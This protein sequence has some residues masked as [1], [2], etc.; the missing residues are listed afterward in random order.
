MSGTKHPRVFVSYSHKDLHLVRKIKKGLK[1]RQPELDVFVATD[2]IH[3]GQPTIDRIVEGIHR[4]SKCLLLVTENSLKSSWFAFETTLSLEWSEQLGRFCCV[5]ILHGISADKLPKFALFDIMPKTQLRLDSN[6]DWEEDHI[7]HVIKLIQKDIPTERQLPVG[8]VA[9]AQAWSHFFGY[10]NVVHGLLEQRIRESK[11]FQKRPGNFPI[12][13]YELISKCCDCSKFTNDKRIKKKGCLKP[14]VINRAGNKT[15]PYSLNVYR[16]EDK[17]QKYYCVAQYPNVLSAILKMEKSE[18]IQME[19]YEKE[20]QLARFN[21]TL[22]A[23]LHHDS[24]KTCHRQSRLVEFDDEHEPHAVLLDAIKTDIREDARIMESWRGK[25]GR[26]QLEDYDIETDS[27]GQSFDAVIVCGEDDE[28]KAYEIKRFLT[29]NHLKV[30][31]LL[32]GSRVLNDLDEATEQCRW[33]VLILTK[34]SLDDS[35]FNLHTINLLTKSISEK[36]VSIIPIVDG[37]TAGRIPTALKWI[38]YIDMRTEGYKERI[39]KAVKGEDIPMA[40]ENALI[41]AGNLG[42]GLAWGYIVNYMKTVLKEFGFYLQKLL[43]QENQSSIL[44]YC[45]EKLY[46]LMPSSCKCTGLVS[47]TSQHVSHFTSFTRIQDDLGGA[48]IVKSLDIY[49]I[50][51]DDNIRQQE[52]YFIGQFPAPV[53][54]LWEM[55]ESRIASIN[56]HTMEREAE[57]FRHTFECLMKGPVGKGLHTKCEIVQFDDTIPNDLQRKLVPILR[58]DT[59]RR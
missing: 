44:R 10:H 7:S 38:T 53:L 3:G 15:R 33:I 31:P 37:L 28:D 50:T 45:P 8:N 11:W 4:S 22:S 55:N 58:R 49:S 32:G 2:D 26:S 30:K 54:C 24:N 21:F 47:D 52:H 13:I 42:Y 18:H 39:C 59:R 9:H 20:M 34:K 17:G 16:I 1:K 19:T 48:N 29:K 36:N 46:V 14:I 43:E 6:G 40:L 25:L 41:P 57:R 5:M 27:V 12:K 23:I 35:V 56:K 51:D